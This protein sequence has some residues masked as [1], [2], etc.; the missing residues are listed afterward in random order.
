MIADAEQVKLDDGVSPSATPCSILID[1][2]ATGGAVDS[3]LVGRGYAKGDYVY[4]NW[5]EVTL[6]PK[7][8]NT[9]HNGIQ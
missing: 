3:R 6:N 9:D 1:P 2:N 5:T 4:A 8:A 7:S